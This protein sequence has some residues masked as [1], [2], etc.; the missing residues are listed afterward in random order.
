MLKLANRLRAVL[1]PREKYTVLLL[2]AAVC[3]SGLLELC[4]IGL[5][6]PVIALFITPELFDQNQL[7]I[8]V[9]HVV[10]DLPFNRFLSVL[11]IGIILFFCF[12]N[13]CL[14][15]ITNFQVRFAFTLASRI[16]ANLLVKYIG[17]RY[18]VSFTR[19]TGELAARI[20][21]SRQ[22][23]DLINSLIMLFSEGLVIL[24]MVASVF[25]LAPLTALSLI[26]IC[27]IFSYLIYLLMRHLVKD[28]SVRGMRRSGILNSYI[29]FTMEALREIKLAGRELFFREKCREMEDQALEPEQKLFLY[30]QIPRF[31]IEAAA[32]VFGMG[33]ILLLLQFQ[34]SPAS[35]ALKVSFIGI[36]LLRMMPSVSRI[37]YYLTRVRSTLPLFET[38]ADDLSRIQLEQIPEKYSSP[39]VFQKEIRLENVAFAYGNK[40]IFSGISL[41]IPRNTSLALVGQTGCGKTT[42]IDL[43][44]GLLF[45]TEG[46]ILADGRDIRENIFSWRKI[47]GYVPQTITLADCSIAE[48]V[49]LGVPPDEINREKVMKCLR[50]AQ[51][52]EFVSRLENGI[53]TVLAERGKNLS[54]GQRQ[55]LGIARALYPD[56]AILI[57]D[58]ATSAL[59]TETEAAFVE[60]LSA[61]NGKFTMIIAAHR[62]ST[63]ENCDQVFRFPAPREKSVLSS[64]LCK[65]SQTK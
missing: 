20:Q 22:I 50:I 12:K 7:L 37:H 35:I 34:V 42:M 6:M 23:S 38:I 58:E 33:T 63:I 47:I 40:R 11:C 45:P 26:V 19:T 53:D 49:A 56:P 60:A 10:G 31:I 24:L 5:I 21:M 16:G 8:F 9:K 30:S 46:K 52:E 61:L 48:N 14:Y 4:G 36:V 1:L 54:G 17:T 29:I 51:A 43:L 15:L 41:T 2:T 27:G 57:F 25:I 28:L 62:L 65:A 59:D 13:L 32:V 39:I 44:A 3:F 55:R 64:P 18:D